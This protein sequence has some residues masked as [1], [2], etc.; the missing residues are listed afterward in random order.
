MIQNFLKFLFYIFNYSSPSI[1]LFLIFTQGH[2]F[3]AFRERGREGERERLPSDAH[4]DWGLNPQPSSLLGAPTEPHWPGLIL[5]CIGLSCKIFGGEMGVWV[6]CLLIPSP[7]LCFSK[8][9]QNISVLTS[10]GSSWNI[11]HQFEDMNSFKV[12]S[13]ASILVLSERDFFCPFSLK[14]ICF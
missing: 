11:I 7:L 8:G 3:I 6:S 12:T 4:P 2:F 9:C 1:L 5:F 10:V 13:S 14:T